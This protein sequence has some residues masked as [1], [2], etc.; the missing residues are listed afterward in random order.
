MRIRLYYSSKDYSEF[1]G[2]KHLSV[3]PKQFS[4]FICWVSSSVLERNYFK[5]HTEKLF[6]NRRLQE[7][8]ES[9]QNLFFGAPSVL[10]PPY[11]P[12]QCLPEM[13]VEVVLNLRRNVPYF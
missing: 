7:N 1:L 9:C 6:R 11:F 8:M 12:I 13:V 3:L 5:A 2:P 4:V 10:P